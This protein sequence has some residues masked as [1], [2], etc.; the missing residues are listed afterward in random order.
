MKK[1][2]ALILAGVLTVGASM[3]AFAANSPSG[4][5]IGVDSATTE[6]GTSVEVV[7]S[8]NY[9]LPGEPEAAKAMEENTEA[10]L[11]EA[12]LTDV[13]AGLGLVDVFDASVI[14]DYDGGPVTITFTVAGVTPSTKVV[15]LH[16]VDGK[17]Q[18]ENATPGNGTITVK[19]QSLSPVAIFVA[20]SDSNGS[21]NGT[22]TSGTTTGSTTTT[23]GS[24]TA[25]PKTGEA[26]VLPIVAVIA[27][28]AVAGMAVS[29]RRKAA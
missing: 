4:N 23:S 25:S 6:D 8:D 5:K 17:W 11:K 21:T 22:T 29:T 14:G 10:T 16:F 19:F 15:V 2:L 9:D 18:E 24:T 27:V 7:V 3:T 20:S 28:M 13:V 12:G 26:P 1:V